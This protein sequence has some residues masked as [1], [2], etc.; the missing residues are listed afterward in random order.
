M[1]PA[2]L[3]TRGLGSVTLRTRAS[4][5][6]RKRGGPTFDARFTV[7]S[8]LLNSLLDSHRY[9]DGVHTLADTLGRGRDE[10]QGLAESYLR[11]MATIHSVA[12]TPWWERFGSWLMRGFEPVV[13]E[14]GLSRLQE[15][16]GEHTLVFLISHRSYLDEWVVPWAVHQAGIDRMSTFAGA[17]LDFFPLG[18]VARRVGM[19]HVKRSSGGDPIY[20][21]VLRSQLGHLVDHEAN[22]MWSIEGGR[23]RTGKLRP[24]RLGLLRYLVDAVEAEDGPEVYVVPTSMLYDQIPVNEVRLMTLEA[25]GRAKRPEN[26]RWF[27]DYISH[28]SSR[29]GRVY[30]N[31]GEPLP[32]RERLAELRARD[33]EGR[34]IVERLAVDVCHRI[35]QATPVTATAAVC[36]ALLGSGRALDAEE[37][38]ET[39]RPIVDY[40]DA[41]GWPTAGGAD[42]RDLAT[43]EAALEALVTTNVLSVHRGSTQVW[44]IAPR[45]HLTAA[46]YRNSAIHVL[47]APAVAEVSLMGAMVAEGDPMDALADTDRLRDL[48]KFEF[49]FPERRQFAAE[50]A[51]EIGVDQTDPDF[52]TVMSRRV[53]AVYF[54]RL[55]IHVSSLVL[56]PYLDAYAVVA[57]TLADDDSLDGIEEERFL[58]RCLGVGR[59]WV[60]RGWLANGESNSLEMFRN[61]F[62][63][64]EHRDLID[65]EAPDV[66]ARRAAFRDE[67]DDYRHRMD[68]IALRRRLALTP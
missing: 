21:Y 8:P 32:L 43:I 31:V 60:L 7:E 28:L 5:R 63:L 54:D 65:Q 29:L 30:I 35:N 1:T 66:R 68:Q 34:S 59:E 6:S 9:Q 26:M 11:Q 52:S 46:N 36:I 3:V 2:E 48:L 61:A 41:R 15:L 37:I 64:A 23:T 19:M 17:N 57:H 67:I 39:I 13:D 50:L 49:F 20:K 16:D 47:L 40:L 56:R 51:R 22:M 33:P 45:Q 53:A 62:R 42:L 4:L 27:L 18:A 25:L 12:V 14:S 38:L 10:V 55:Q 24:P 44:S 58:E